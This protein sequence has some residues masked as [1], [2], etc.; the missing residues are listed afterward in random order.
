MKALLKLP[1]TWH[2]VVN[3]ENIE[4]LEQWRFGEINTG[5]MKNGYVVGMYKWEDGRITKEH[6]RLVDKDFG[7]EISTADFK[8]LVLFQKNF[9]DY[10][11]LGSKELVNWFE[12]NQPNMDGK[13]HNR[14]FYFNGMIGVQS[15]IV[16]LKKYYYHYQNI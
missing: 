12:N 4:L 8:R 15:I 2:V 9:G 7:Q 3:D 5:F 6:N 16:G 14:V 11:V 13:N 10:G 1:E